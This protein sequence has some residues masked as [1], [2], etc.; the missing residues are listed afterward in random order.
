METKTD[1]RIIKTEKVIREAF[2]T[3]RKKT[4]LEKMKVS[5][6]CKTAMINPSTFY[7]HYSDVIALS[8]SIENDLVHKCLKDH[9]NTDCLFTDP[10]RYLM[11]FQQTLLKNEEELNIVFAGRQGVMLEKTERIM[12]AH[13]LSGNV[14]EETKVKVIF[15]MGG[16]I[17]T[18]TVLNRNQ[19]YPAEELCRLLANLIHK[20]A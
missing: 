3:L 15:A 8:E 9:C 11:S 14:D 5:E 6:I 7:K 1:L 18:S 20:L 12:R 13:Y 10:Y 17:H 4:P 19:D 2:M 16:I